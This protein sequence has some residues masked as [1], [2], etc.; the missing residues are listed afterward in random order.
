MLTQQR[1]KELVSYDPETGEMRWLNIT[2]KRVHV[3]D[4]VGGIQSDGR[5]LTSIDGKRYRLHRLAWLYMTGSFPSDEFQIDHINRIPSDNRWC[6]LRLATS[7]QNLANRKMYSSNTSGHKG[8]RFDAQRRKWRVNLNFGGTKLMKR[9][10]TLEEA[11]EARDV[12][13]QKWFG[14]FRPN[15][16]YIKAS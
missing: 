1:L 13:E 6:N 16:T 14:S 2:S 3:G 15:D 7:S 10:D 8:I 9:Y 4:I 5:T 11:I 12:A